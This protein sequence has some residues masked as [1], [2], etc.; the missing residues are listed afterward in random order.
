MV[1]AKRSF[2]FYHFDS[3]YIAFRVSGEDKS[4]KEEEAEQIP[5]TMEQAYEELDQIVTLLNGPIFGSRD[6]VEQ[7]K[8]ANPNA[9]RNYR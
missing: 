1:C 6:M 3:D 7:L 4:A 2:Y 8:T 9:G 5:N